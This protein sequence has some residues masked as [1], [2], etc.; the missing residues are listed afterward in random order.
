MESL[1]PNGVGCKEDMISFCQMLVG[2]SLMRQCFDYSSRM[3]SPRQ[4][5]FLA[6]IRGGC[7]DNTPLFGLRDCVP[8]VMAELK[9]GCLGTERF[10]PDSSVS[11]GVI[12]GGSLF[13]PAQIS[14]SSCSCCINFGAEGDWNTHRQCD[15]VDFQSCKSGLKYEGVLMAALHG[16]RRSDQLQDLVYLT[17]AVRAFVSVT[18]P[19]NR[20]CIAFHSHKFGGS[21]VSTDPITSLSWGRTG[22]LVL[23]PK[24]KKAQGRT[25][26]IVQMHG[27]ITIMAGE[28]QQFFQHASPPVSEWTA[29][30]EVHR[31]ELKLWEIAAM[32]VEIAAMNDG[33]LD[34]LLRQNVTL[35]WINSHSNCCWSHDR[36]MPMPKVSVSLS[37]ARLEA[38]RFPMRVPS[39]IFK[40]GT[41]NSSSSSASN[42]ATRSLSTVFETA[43]LTASG[44]ATLCGNTQETVDMP[45][46]SGVMV[47]MAVQTDDVFSPFPTSSL[48][49]TAACLVA[50][51]Y[52]AVGLLRATL[53]SCAFTGSEHDWHMEQSCMDKLQDFIHAMSCNLTRFDDF[54]ADMGVDQQEP[55]QSIFQVSSKCLHILRTALDDRFELKRHVDA[56][57][58]L[59]ATFYETKVSTKQLSIPSSKWLT[60]VIMSHA[61]FEELI[62]HVDLDS[63]SR[64][65]DVV[66]KIPRDMMFDSSSEGPEYLVRRDDMV[67]IGFLDIGIFSDDTVRRMH[68]RVA[69]KPVAPTGVLFSAFDDH[70]TATA[71]L[72]NVTNVLMR[73]LSHVRILEVQLSDGHRSNDSL[74]QSYDLRLW[75]ASNQRRQMFLNRY[76]LT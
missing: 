22:V 33:S 67:Y 66:L 24:F 19:R 23:R 18:D 40:L 8:E 76:Q 30:L 2:M 4:D 5:C 64:H 72:Q 7:T 55:F 28:F 63:L 71:L 59:G 13:E 11:T 58:V 51:A 12:Y 29:L 75:I 9:A 15:H 62:Q 60:S 17:K 26:L 43:L 21:Y 20:H 73:C 69:P 48:L 16:N 36:L 70:R 32:Q 44:E 6:F 57:K 74:S 31:N 37:I 14:K 25:H 56:L 38:G 3:P 1:W 46:S 47:E 53:A 10:C 54:L 50:E 39:R 52:S 68:L 41:S 27:D 45:V 34:P 65:G 61:V 35:R 49:Q 42:R